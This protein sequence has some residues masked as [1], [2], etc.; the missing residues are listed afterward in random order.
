MIEVVHVVKILKTE[1]PTDH[2]TFLTTV[3][4]QK[5][6][7]SKNRKTFFKRSVLAENLTKIWT[8]NFSLWRAKHANITCKVSGSKPNVNFS[9]IYNWHFLR[10]PP[11]VLRTK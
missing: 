1:K 5:H 3:S 6:S 4:Q 7:A 9:F 2:M 10:F 11:V 8:S